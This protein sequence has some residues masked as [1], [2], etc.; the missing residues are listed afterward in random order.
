MHAYSD[1]ILTRF[2][3]QFRAL[4][5]PLVELFG[6]CFARFCIYLGSFLA[7]FWRHEVPG[8]AFDPIDAK[9]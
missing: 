9:M 5:H 3:L 8:E 1:V 6:S 2:G 4:L 7:P